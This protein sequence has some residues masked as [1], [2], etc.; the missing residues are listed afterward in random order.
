M[1][2]L[3][4]KTGRGPHAIAFDTGDDGSGNL[5]SYLYVG[6]FTDSY[7]GVVDLD[8]RHPE[9]FGIMF[10]SIGTPTEPRESK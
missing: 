9:T 8:M 10:A 2:D 3:I 7:L 5:H 1:V 4:I 6:H